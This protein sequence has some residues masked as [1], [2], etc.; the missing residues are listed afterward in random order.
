VFV[1]E[2][3]LV[4]VIVQIGLFKKRVFQWQKYLSTP[5]NKPLQPELESCAV[6]EGTEP[7]N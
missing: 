1:P 7:D 4:L 3:K 6:V 2:D 5:P